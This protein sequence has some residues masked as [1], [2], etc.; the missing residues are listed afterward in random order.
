MPISPKFPKLKIGAGYEAGDSIPNALGWEYQGEKFLIT[1]TGR[2]YE[3]PDD[4][5]YDRQY[6]LCFCPEGQLP[7]IIH[8][9]A[10]EEK[11]DL[12]SLLVW[13]QHVINEPGDLFQ[14]NA[15]WYRELQDNSCSISTMEHQTISY[16]TNDATRLPWAAFRGLV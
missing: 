16:W 8:V 11:W 12:Q 2:L 13:A 15:E 3:C 1:E 6:I 7:T 14:V 10:H 5:G 9:P 4:A